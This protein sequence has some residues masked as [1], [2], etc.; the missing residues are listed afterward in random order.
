MDEEKQLLD[1]DEVLGIRESVS[2]PPETETMRP[3]GEAGRVSEAAE[4][5]KR[6]DSDVAGDEPDG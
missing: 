6:L 3:A 5:R 4:A 2:G 1:A